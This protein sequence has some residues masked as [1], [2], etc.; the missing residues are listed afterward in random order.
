MV[1]M[2]GRTTATSAVVGLLIACSLLA[3]PGSLASLAPHA[4]LIPPS[5]AHPLG[6]DDLG[7]D[8]LAALLQGGQTS[9]FVATV[10]SALALLI[11]LGAG[12]VSGIGSAALDDAMMRVTEITASLPALLLAVLMAALFGGSSWNLALLLGVTRW[13]LIARIVRTETRALLA[14]DFMRAAWA[15]GVPP[16]RIAWK[17]VLPHLAAPLRASGGIV[18]GGAIV[19]ESA[20]AFIGLGDPAATSWGQMVASG[21]AMFGLGWWMWL[22][23]AAMIIAVTGLVA[24]ASDRDTA[25]V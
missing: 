6:T 3:P 5:L 11:G 24:A 25:G 18:F 22:W 16:A 20:L 7:R 8:M 10:A 23:P 19:S 2:T 14:R 21:F 4:A 13:P 12:L 15:L 9:L 1:A 17:H